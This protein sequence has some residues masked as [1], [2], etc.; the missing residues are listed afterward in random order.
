MT[1][2]VHRL[3]R[4]SG[5]QHPTCRC[6]SGDSPHRLRLAEAAAGLIEGSCCTPAALLAEIKE[7]IE[8]GIVICRR[9]L[10]ADSADE[11]PFGEAAFTSCCLRILPGV[12]GL[13][14]AGIQSAFRL[15]ACSSP[16]SN[17]PSDLLSQRYLR[18]PDN[19][20]DLC[21]RSCK[22]P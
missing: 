11:L 4:A 10:A 8:G 2:P 14:L 22:L 19:F 18:D 9:C 17:Q 7:A 20:G 12:L 3:T 15:I 6:L 5:K 16:V 21:W 1:S 13:Q